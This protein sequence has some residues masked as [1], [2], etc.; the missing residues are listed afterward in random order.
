MRPAVPPIEGR[1]AARARSFAVGVGERLIAADTADTVRGLN[2][3]AGFALLHCALGD[4][5]G[6]ERFTAAMHAGIRRAALLDGRPPI[7]LFGGISGLRAAAAL[8]ARD[9]PRYSK[10]LAQC[11]AY[12]D[13]LLPQ[14]PSKPQ[15]FDDYDLI[16]G[17]S[18]ARLARGVCGACE[19]D[20]LVDLIVWTLGDLERW[21]CTHPLRSG[22]PPLNDLGIAHGLAGV[23]AALTLTV[24]PLDGSAGAA[25]RY[26]LNE[27]RGARVELDDCTVWPPALP[28]QRTPA[29]RSAW[30]Y[31]AAGVAAVLHHAAKVL[32]DHETARMAA[33]AVR[34]LAAQPMESWMLE[35]EAL[36]H[37]L[38]GNALCFA[39]VASATHD[40]QLCAA[41]MR[42]AELVL[43]RLDENDGRCWAR[44]GSMS[45]YDAVELLDGVSGIALALLTLTGDAD[46]AWMRCFGLPPIA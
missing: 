6:D 42:V 27:L 5:T 4:L 9:E 44:D 18:G 1:L 34:E 2:G 12:V 41:A 46:S 39:A 7:G 33:R 26:A 29:H 45:Y 15:T 14:H 30:C 17:W 3:V 28:A 38:M 8:A 40:P 35:G 19:S 31:G 23:L 22:E 36:C 11:D 24:E 32:A 21:R 10:L 37:G 16:S 20:A 25:A 43:D 13:S